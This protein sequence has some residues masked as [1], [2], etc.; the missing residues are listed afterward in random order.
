MYGPPVAEGS[1]VE[2]ELLL[3]ESPK[4]TLL[5]VVLEEVKKEAIQN[6]ACEQ[7]ERRGKGEIVGGRANGRVGRRG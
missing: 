3:E 5:S 6:P 4:W 2:R 1:N 7:R